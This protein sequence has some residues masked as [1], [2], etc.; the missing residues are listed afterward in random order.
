MVSKMA[1]FLYPQGHR[2]P[3][4]APAWR[5]GAWR[6]VEFK[7]KANTTLLESEIILPKNALFY[8]E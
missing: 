7:Q 5:P 6:P 8:L 4:A 3:A 2:S 1:K